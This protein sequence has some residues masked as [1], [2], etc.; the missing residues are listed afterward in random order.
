MSPLCT[1]ADTKKTEA[2][3]QTGTEAHLQLQRQGRQ[4]LFRM[5]HST[6]DLG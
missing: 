3:A 1:Y 5:I 6:L 2:R 4:G